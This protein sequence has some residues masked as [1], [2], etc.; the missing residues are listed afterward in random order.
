MHSEKNDWLTG[1]ETNEHVRQKLNLLLSFLVGLLLFFSV[2][3]LLVLKRRKQTQNTQNQS[4][5][6]SLM[7]EIGCLQHRCQLFSSAKCMMT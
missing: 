3:F 2:S 7:T 5:V 6:W 4:E 1:K